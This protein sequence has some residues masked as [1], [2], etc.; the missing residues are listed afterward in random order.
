MGMEVWVWRYGYGEVPISNIK[1]PTVG[2]GSIYF[3]NSHK[4][5]R[6]WL[7]TALQVVLLTS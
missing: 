3:I 2:C 7:G 4:R 5:L 1:L 6:V